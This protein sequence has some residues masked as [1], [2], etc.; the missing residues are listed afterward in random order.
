[1]D[2]FWVEITGNLVKLA[3]KGSYDLIAHGCNCKK[4][5]GA[6]IA[7]EIKASFPMA[8]EVDKASTP[9][10]GE[11]SVCDYYKEC[12]IINAYTQ[13]NPGSNGHGKD[14]DYN[15]YEAVRSCM[16]VINE[17]FPG[18]HIGLPLIASGLAGLKWSKVKKI[19]EE[20]LKDMNV[21]IVHFQK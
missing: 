14:T 8:Y 15:R 7:K 10:M 18:K 20:E 4:N 16:K 13:Y 1:M 3:K 19:I 5:M 11:I 17:R 21:T 9:K 12:T 2:H 6:G